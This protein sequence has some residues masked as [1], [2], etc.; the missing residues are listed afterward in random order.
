[1]PAGMRVFYCIAIT[2][3]LKAPAKS[4]FLLLILRIQ[5][6]SE[7]DVCALVR[8]D[9]QNEKSFAIQE[10]IYKNYPQKRGY[11]Y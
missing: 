6:P 8:E 9:S 11:F 1:M 5:K 4:V 2:V 7:K 10:K 3:I